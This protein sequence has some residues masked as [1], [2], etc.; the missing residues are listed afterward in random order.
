MWPIVF[1]NVLLT[2]DQKTGREKDE[3]TSM[4]LQELLDLLGH[5][6]AVDLLHFFN[7]PSQF[8]W[9]SAPGRQSSSWKDVDGK[10][11][12][13]VEKAACGTVS[14]VSPILFPAIGPLRDLLDQQYTGGNGRRLRSQLFARSLA[15]SSRTSH[16][17]SRPQSPTA[18]RQRSDSPP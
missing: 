10:P 3:P 4:F 16:P 1:I 17:R 13:S 18:A 14:N 6:N 12:H 7:A 8:R 2:M 5:M 9:K 15:A 11:T